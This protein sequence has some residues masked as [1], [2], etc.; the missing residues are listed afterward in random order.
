MDAQFADHAIVN[1]V[2]TEK[3]HP[4]NVTFVI[5]SISG[6]LPDTS[7]DTNAE[8]VRF[9]TRKNLEEFSTIV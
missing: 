5:Q 6:T 8:N 9:L 1:F 4:V 2:K 7:H 3:K